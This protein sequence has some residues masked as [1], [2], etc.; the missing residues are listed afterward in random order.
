M[1]NYLGKLHYSSTKTDYMV[2][3]LDKLTIQQ[4]VLCKNILNQL[5]GLTEGVKKTAKVVFNYQKHLI[6]SIYSQLQ[7]KT[8]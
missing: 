7:F 5:I 3:I 6:L 2:I 8:R 1:F 4:K